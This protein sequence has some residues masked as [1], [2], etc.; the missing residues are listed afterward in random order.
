[1]YETFEH[2]ADLGLRVKAADL[3]TLFAEAGRGL[4]SIIVA[5]L[6]EVRPVRAVNIALPSAPLDE[7]LFD[8]LAEILYAFESERLLL[9]EFKAS[10]DNTGLKAVARGE[11]V[12]ESRHRL[13]H[14]IKAITY[15]GLKVEQTP[16][17][18]LAEVIVDI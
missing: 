1:M 9:T 10:I 13:E 4:T 15:H 6:E 7:L 16:D 12:D 18:F 11:P 17:G 2:T 3:P 14:E 5:N 8:W